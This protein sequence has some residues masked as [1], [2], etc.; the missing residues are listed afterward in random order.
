MCIIE[1]IIEENEKGFA[2]HFSKYLIIKQRH[3]VQSFFFADE[4]DC[5]CMRFTVAAIKTM[6]D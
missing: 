5:Y 6:F 3:N 2:H 1:Q 4:T